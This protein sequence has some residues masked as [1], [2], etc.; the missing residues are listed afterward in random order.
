MHPAPINIG[1]DFHPPSSA[2]K[3]YESGHD[4]RTQGAWVIVTYQREFAETINQSGVD[5]LIRFLSERNQ[6][7]ASGKHTREWF[8]HQEPRATR[9]QGFR[10]DSP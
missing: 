4:Y 8:G 3:E 9:C 7:L 6:K 5:G 10:F 1:S 2:V